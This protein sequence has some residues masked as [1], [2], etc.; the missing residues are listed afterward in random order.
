MR[1]PKVRPFIRRYR[2]ASPLPTR[3]WFDRREYQSL[4]GSFLT[5]YELTF[6]FPRTDIV[7][8]VEITR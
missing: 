4:G 2:Y 8:G 7:F 5:T 3:V 1:L 6:Q